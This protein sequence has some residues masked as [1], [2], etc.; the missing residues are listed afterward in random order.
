MNPAHSSRW[1][2]KADPSAVPELRLVVVACMRF[3]PREWCRKS[4]KS[5]NYSKGSSLAK[6]RFPGRG[7]RGGGRLTRP[8]VKPTF[9]AP[10]RDHRDHRAP[11]SSPS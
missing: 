6:P 8:G 7:R 4:Q 2:L 3:T 11:A 9:P 1:A 10:D 5:E